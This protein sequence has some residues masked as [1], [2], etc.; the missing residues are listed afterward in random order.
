MTHA[1]LKCILQKCGMTS[2]ASKQ[3]TVTLINVST[4]A[5]R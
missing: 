1:S 4:G 5:T 3:S 2:V